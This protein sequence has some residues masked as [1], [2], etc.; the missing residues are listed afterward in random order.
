VNG[1]N[2]NGAFWTWLALLVSA[3]AV[4]GSLW[5]SLGMK[6]IACPLCFYQRTFALSVF[7][8]LA[9]GLLGG[10]RR[11]R[12]LCLVALPLAVG[13][14]GVAGW[15]VSLEVRGKL[16]CPGGIFG[17]GTAPQQSLAAFVVLTLPLLLGAVM[18]PG[19]ASEGGAGRTVLAVVAAFVLGGL[20]AVGCVE[21]TTL[22]KL[23]AELTEGAPTICRP[24]K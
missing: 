4:A 22:V 12:L 1:S 21:S 16:E 18:G 8:V 3:V 15:H 7:G 9:I 13:G 19:A 2:E 24:A 10:G 14:L 17:L 23:P 11:G 20:F 6:L 5:L